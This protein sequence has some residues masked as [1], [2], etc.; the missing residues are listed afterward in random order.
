[1]DDTSDNYSDGTSMGI[2]KAIDTIDTPVDVTPAVNVEL[3]F[4]SLGKK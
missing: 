2:F 3:P 1:M 4:K